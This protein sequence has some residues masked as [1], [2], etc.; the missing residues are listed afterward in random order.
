MK[1]LAISL[2]V[3]A[4]ASCNSKRSIGHT[5]TPEPFDYYHSPAVLTNVSYAGGD[6][7]SIENAI[8]ILNAGNSRNGIAAEYAYIEKIHGQK[9]K[10]WKVLEQSTFID[11][12]RRFDQFNIMLIGSNESITYYFDIT[13]FYGK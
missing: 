3:L 9:F 13:E 4:V 1:L 2:V 11:N 8:L 12:G 7:S 5:T 6:G 10:D